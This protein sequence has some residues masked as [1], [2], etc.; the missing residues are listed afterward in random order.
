[1]GIEIVELVFFCDCDTMN[2]GNLIGE[3]SVWE[4][5]LF[6]EEMEDRK[7][8]SWLR[9]LYLFIEVVLCT[10]REFSIIQS[11]KDEKVLF[12]IDRQLI[13]SLVVPFEFLQM[14]RNSAL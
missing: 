10:P 4:Q 3:V 11:A 13:L 5:F 6:I 8:S 7:R 14:A 2:H 1:M 12:A 9:S